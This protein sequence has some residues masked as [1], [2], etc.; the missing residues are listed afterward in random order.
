MGYNVTLETGVFPNGEK[1]TFVTRNPYVR[2]YLDKSKKIIQNKQDQYEC[3]FDDG[4]AFTNLPTLKAHLSNVHDREN[5]S[6]PAQPRRR[7]SPN[8]KQFCLWMRHDNTFP[9]GTKKMRAELNADV[10][11]HAPLCLL[12]Y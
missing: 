6:E 1:V 3:P 12:L 5:G 9:D 11:S 10:T 7:N 8:A 4:K 2:P